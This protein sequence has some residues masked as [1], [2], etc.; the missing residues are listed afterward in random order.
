MS[1]EAKENILRTILEIRKGGEQARLEE[2]GER[3]GLKKEELEKATSALKDE[4][5]VTVIDGNILLTP[6]GRESAEG[7]LDRHE[8]TEAFFSQVIGE[9]GPQ[10]HEIASR[11]EHIISEMALKELKRVLSFRQGSESLARLSPGEG[12]VITAVGV[13]DSKVFDRLMG[14][15]ISPGNKLKIVQRMPNG[16]FILE[17][18]QVKVAI[19][20]ELAQQ[21]LVNT[22]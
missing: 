17:L 14:M 22:R 4:G 8:V 7:I 12:G 18:N 15:G 16:A 9:P 19:S 2:L 1:K 5:L 6:L 3:T 13:I 21:I 10:A 20:K 11:L